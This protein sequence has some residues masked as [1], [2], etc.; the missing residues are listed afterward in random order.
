[1]GKVDLFVYCLASS[2]RGGCRRNDGAFVLVT[3]INIKEH[4]H[5]TCGSFQLEADRMRKSAAKEI[6]AKGNASDSA[7]VSSNVSGRAEEGRGGNG[8]RGSLDDDFS[9][10]GGNN[11]G[12]RGVSRGKSIRKGGLAGNDVE[13]D[14]NE[15]R[16]DR[17][18]RVTEEKRG[19]RGRGAYQV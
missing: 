3:P 14:Y 2:G 11:T 1:M 9:D 10:D 17:G 16:G 8:R 19:G 12:G 7:G 5:V 18:K 15:R 13:D 4:P 6:A